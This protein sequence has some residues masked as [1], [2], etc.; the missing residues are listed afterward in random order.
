MRPDM[1][2]EPKNFAS[3]PRCGAKT[4][5]GTPCQR[6][7]NRKS[8]RCHLHGGKSPGVPGNRNAMKTGAYARPLTPEEKRR[9]RQLKAELG[10]LDSEITL[11]RWRLENIVEQMQKWEAEHP[12]GDALER[13]EEIRKTGMELERSQDSSGSTLIFRK[14]DFDGLILRY[15]GLIRRL[16]ETRAKLLE[17]AVLEEMRADLD[18]LIAA[19]EQAR[20]DGFEEIPEPAIEV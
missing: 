11:L 3:V 9:F 18:K 16:E 19:K 6:A 13:V 14:R 4:R 10:G 7:G 20:F 15:T 2:Q 5:S 17:K 8:G 1:N 12:D